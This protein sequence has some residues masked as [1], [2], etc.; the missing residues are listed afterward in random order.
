[1]SLNWPK[2][3]YGVTP[4]RVQLAY[5]S[6]SYWFRSEAQVTGVDVLSDVP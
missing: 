6:L 4:E 5:Q 1:M 3:L 2:S